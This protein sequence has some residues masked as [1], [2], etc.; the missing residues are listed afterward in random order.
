MSRPS[1][2][3]IQKVKEYNSKPVVINDWCHYITFDAMGDL[4]F[5]RSYGQ[6]EAGRL[7]PGVTI[8]GQWLSIA[9]LTFQVPWLMC[10]MQRIPMEGPEETMRKFAAASLRQREKVGATFN[11]YSRANEVIMIPLLYRK[12]PS[13]QT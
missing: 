6:L 12:S 13:I 7:H 11:L 10:V 3:F 9:V 4:A 5:G 1:D 2:L 8:I